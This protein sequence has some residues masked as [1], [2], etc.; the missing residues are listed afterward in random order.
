MLVLY[1]FAIAYQYSR[2]SLRNITDVKYAILISDSAHIVVLKIHG[3]GLHGFGLGFGLL[4]CC[5]YNPVCS[6]TSSM[7]YDR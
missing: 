4:C 3:P 2:L 5:T 7:P 6:S 1:Q